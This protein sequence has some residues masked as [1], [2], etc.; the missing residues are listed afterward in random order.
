[1][2]KKTWPAYAASRK[3]KP[4]EWECVTK[5]SPETALNPAR[6]EYLKAEAEKVGLLTEIRPMVYGKRPMG[7]FV[8][9]PEKVN[10]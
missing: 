4:G 6:L 3:D 1:M 8:A 5:P 10:T 2:A 7:L 9:Y